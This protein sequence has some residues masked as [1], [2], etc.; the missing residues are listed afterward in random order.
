MKQ[1]THC[2]WVESDKYINAENYHGIAPFYPPKNIETSYGEFLVDGCYA[3][4]RG[5]LF[6][7]NSPAINTDDSKRGAMVHDFF[8]MLMKDNLLSRDYRK[9]VDM[10][11]RYILLEDG[12]LPIRAR[13]WYLAVRV[14]GDNALDSARPKV[15][16][17]PK[18]TP[19]DPI[20]NAQKI[21]GK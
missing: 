8:Y 20:K 3:I 11:F 13:Y 7:A 12:M 2:Y 10:L 6:S 14:G 1:D 21:L 19:Q 5:F 15:N 16:K 4:N 18:E 17:S 9:P